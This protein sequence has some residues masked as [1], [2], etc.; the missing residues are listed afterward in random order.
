MQTIVL[1]KLE[2]ACREIFA[3]VFDVL[4]RGALHSESLSRYLTRFF[5]LQVRPSP[6]LMR[7]R[8]IW[9]QLSLALRTFPRLCCNRRLANRFSH[10]LPNELIATQFRDFSMSTDTRSASDMC[11]V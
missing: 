4:E 1:P 7:V 10:K 9:H 5:G 6:F 3:Q 2:A 8:E 11:S